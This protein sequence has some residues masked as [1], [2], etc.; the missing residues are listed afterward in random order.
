MRAFKL[1]VPKNVTIF[2]AASGEK[3]TL[4]IRLDAVAPWASSEAT[5]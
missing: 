3:D 2:V 5:Q 4:E 1:R